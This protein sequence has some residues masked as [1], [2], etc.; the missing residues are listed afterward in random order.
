MTSLT[1]GVVSLSRPADDPGKILYPAATA[2][3]TTALCDRCSYHQDTPKP[4]NSKNMP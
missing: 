4:H 3:A 2:T 1:P